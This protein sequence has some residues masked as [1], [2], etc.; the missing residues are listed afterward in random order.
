MTEA[1]QARE[2]QLAK[3]DELQRRSEHWLEVALNYEADGDTLRSTNAL[4]V[5]AGIEAQIVPLED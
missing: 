2:F 1:Q 4:K 3:N 5:A